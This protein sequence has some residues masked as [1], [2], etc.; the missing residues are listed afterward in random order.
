MKQKSNRD[1]LSLSCL[2]TYFFWGGGGSKNELA[3]PLNR[4]S[5]QSEMTTLSVDH[6]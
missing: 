5:Q 2:K 6:R 4:W 1:M 3:K